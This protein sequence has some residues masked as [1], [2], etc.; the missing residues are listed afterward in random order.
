MKNDKEMTKTDYLERHIPHRINLLITF[1]ERYG[2]LKKEPDSDRD[3]YRC[4][5]DIS[6]LMVRFLLQELGINFK[7]R[8]KN[9]SNDIS[10]GFVRNNVKGLKVI[11]LQ[12]K[13]IIQDKNFYTDLI[14]VLKAANRAIAHLE[15]ED[16]NHELDSHAKTIKILIP[17]INFVEEKVIQNIYRG[18]IKYYTSVM[19]S[20]SNDMR[21]N[22]SK[23][24][25]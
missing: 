19:E 2:K 3:F 8:K 22:V 11:D 18:D 5:K 15:N 21:R 12:E 24:K 16:V 9:K 25:N 10:P 14:I 23:P 17:V 20:P 7:E 1:R 6:I 13:D 4:A